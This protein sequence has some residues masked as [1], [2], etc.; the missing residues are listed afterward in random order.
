EDQLS[1]EAEALRRRHASTILLV[2]QDADEFSVHA[3]TA[4]LEEKLGAPR[5]ENEQIAYIIPK[6]HIQTWLTYMDGQ[7]VDESGKKTYKGKYGKISESKEAHSLIDRLADHC[8]KN[9]E[10]ESPPDSLAAAC[11]E[12]DRIRAAL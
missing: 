3:I 6:W 8:M 9:R 2:I 1:L 5:G 12:F 11:E 4:W 7:N 10:L